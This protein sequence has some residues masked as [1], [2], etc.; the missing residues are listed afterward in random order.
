MYL[1]YASVNK[2]DIY[3]EFAAIESRDYRGMFF[4]NGRFNS[5]EHFRREVH[6]PV[7]DFTNAPETPETYVINFLFVPS[8]RASQYL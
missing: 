1:Y 6:Q 2:R 3:D 8:E 7:G 4:L 5:L